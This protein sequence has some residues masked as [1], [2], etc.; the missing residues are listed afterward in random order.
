MHQGVQA[1][2]TPD[3]HHADGDSDQGDDNAA[4]NI[5]EAHL[6]IVRDRQR[7][8]GMEKQPVVNAPAAAASR[9]K[10]AIPQRRIVAAVEGLRKNQRG[11]NRGAEEGADGA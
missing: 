5:D 11:G 9:G 7:K 3:G 8:M 2:Q 1:R 4:E 10:E 6:T